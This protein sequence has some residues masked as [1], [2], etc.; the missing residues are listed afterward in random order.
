VAPAPKARKVASKFAAATETVTPI[1]GAGSPAGAE[2]PSIPQLPDFTMP[3]SSAPIA[4]DLP[5]QPPT[6]MKD[7]MDNLEPTSARYEEVAS[8]SKANMEAL[9]EANSV[10]LNG[11]Q[12]LSK[13]VFSLTQQTLEQAAATTAAMLAAKTL[14]DVMA[15][16]SEFAKANYEKMLHNTTKIGEM[17]VKLATATAAPITARAT[18]LVEKSVRPLT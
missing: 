10:F 3:V 14:K 7:M 17:T 16:N 1:L 18:H 4:G 6:M 2:A 15:L 8:F 12:E 13:E 5:T 11:F 9:M